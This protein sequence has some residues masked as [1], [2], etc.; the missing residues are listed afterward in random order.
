MLVQME[1][2]AAGLELVGDVVELQM[3]L[4]ALIIHTVY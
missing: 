1:K 2:L 3:L 4:V